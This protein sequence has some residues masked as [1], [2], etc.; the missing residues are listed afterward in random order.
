MPDS[1]YTYSVQ[2]SDKSAAQ[3][4]TDWS[5]ARS[6]TTDPQAGDVVTITKA[7]FRTSKSELNVEAASIS[8][9]QAELIVYDFSGDI[10]YGVM[11]YSSRN[12]IYKLKIRGVDD[13]FL[14]DPFS[15]VTV[16]SSWDGEGTMSVTYK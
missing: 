16:I 14:Y 4:P 7:E 15:R 3:N 12:D 5:N 2:A 8:G 6:A 10:E 9:G 1:T 13:P 11:T